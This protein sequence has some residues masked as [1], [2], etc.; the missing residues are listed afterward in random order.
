MNKENKDSPEVTLLILN[1]NG[2]KY[3]KNCLD[4]V[5]KTDYPKLKVVMID[6]AST[7]GSLE[8]VEKHYPQV[9]FLKNHKNHG[10]AKAY[11]KALQDVKS[12]LVL[13]LNNDTIVEPDWLRQLMPY[14]ANDKQVSALNPKILLT[15]NKNVINAAGG[16]CDL[17]GIGW[18]R[19]NGEVDGGQY[20]SVEEVFY[21]N[22]AAML[23]RRDAWKNV[24]SFD[25]QYFMYGEDLDW[26][27]R[28]RLKGY[29]IL[30]IPKSRIR[31]EW[32]ASKGQIIALLERHWLAT[33]LKNY[34]LANLIKLA[35]KLLALKT[36]KAL[37]LFKNGKNVDEKLAVFDGFL[38]NLSIFRKTWKKRLLIQSSRR[39]SD[40]ELQKHMYNG[41]FELL[42]GFGKIKHPLVKS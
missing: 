39:V 5:L 26:C 12:D 18:N 19:G 28:A 3:I 32:R 17:F 4:S 1:Y 14:I 11:N 37:W 7:D 8:Y 38:W 42:L 22:G 21:A 40:E 9:K 29:K 2:A 30:Y 31:H 41:S 34:G 33:F 16:N 20:E 24:G 10:F 6:N 35:P 25:D 23:I 13:L 36:L 15:Q 27:W